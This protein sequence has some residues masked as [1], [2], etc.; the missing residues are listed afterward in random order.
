MK[1]P[2]KK[3]P[4]PK[5]EYGFA[6]P[7][8]FAQ[9]SSIRSSSAPIGYATIHRDID[10]VEFMPILIQQVADNINVVVWEEIVAKV[11]K[12]LQSHPKFE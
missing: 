8:R 9:L 10:G 11:N 6:N 12:S 1:N 4:E 2:F 7:K 3:K 5:K